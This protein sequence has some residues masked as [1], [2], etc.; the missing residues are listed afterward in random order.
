[1]NIIKGLLQW[2]AML[3]FNERLDEVAK[4]LK[5]DMKANPEKYRSQRGASGFVAG[6]DGGGSCSGGGGD[7]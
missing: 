3:S 4:E 2:L 1:M 6:T 5:A 7:C